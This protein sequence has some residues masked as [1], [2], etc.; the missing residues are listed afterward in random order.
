[1]KQTQFK[2]IVNDYKDLIYNQAYYFTSH[3]DDAEDITQ[4]VLIKLWHHQRNIKRVSLKTWLLK[5]T[6]NLCI[7]YSRKRKELFLNEIHNDTS[8]STFIE[9]LVDPK[10]NP[11]EE[12]ISRDLMENITHVI[13]ELPEKI[14]S[15]VIMRDIQDLTYDIISKTMG[16]P[17][18]SVKVYIH[19]GRKLLLKNLLEYSNNDFQQ[20]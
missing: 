16:L 12:I 10:L 15:I 5:V 2:K 8:K 14:R 20:E 18:N 13:N 9:S 19:R 7:D 17:L 6:R 11:E 3:K 1:M 4:E